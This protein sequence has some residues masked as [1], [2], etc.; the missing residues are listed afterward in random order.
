MFGGLRGGLQTIRLDGSGLTA[1][2]PEYAHSASFSPD[3]S[4]L[5]FTFG[6]G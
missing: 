4:A 3:G 2:A 1:V 5:A 6:Q